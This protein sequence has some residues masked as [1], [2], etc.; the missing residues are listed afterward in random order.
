MRWIGRTLAMLGMIVTALSGGCGV[1]ADTEV[2]W[3]LWERFAER[4][5]QTDGRIVDCSV[6]DC[7]ST[8]ESQSYGL[9]FALVANDR[10][11][12]DTILKWTVDNLAQ[13]DMYRTLPAWLWGERED[14]TWGVIDDNSATDS[15]LWI[16]Y[17]LLEAA[18]LWHEPRYAELGRA[19]ADNVVAEAMVDL[20]DGGPIVLPAPKGFHLQPGVWRFN[21]SYIPPFLMRGLSWHDPEGPWR[22]VAATHQK[23]L[24]AASPEEFAP[25]WYIYDR[26]QGVRA[27]TVKG[28]IGSYDAI[29]VYLWSGMSSGAYAPNRAIGGMERALRRHEHP[30][31]RVNVLTGETY[32]VGPVGFSAALLPYLARRNARDAFLRQKAR[33]DE[34][35]ADGKLKELP[36]YDQVLMLFG[37][38]RTE[39]YY[40][41]SNEGLLMPRWSRQ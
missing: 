8:S 15:D 22:F 25:D 9:F 12:F 30:P 32:G 26:E 20:P 39:D 10:Q 21:P 6:D 38:G 36:Y 1:T 37:L 4:M 24:D 19:V 31:E 40:R 17:V 35:L 16:A 29:R 3:P 34:A 7:R 33:V 28:P 13:G 41:F 5:M 27:D 18:R 11:R 2:E 23:L 14:G